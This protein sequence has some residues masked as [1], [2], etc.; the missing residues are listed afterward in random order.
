MKHLLRASHPARG[1][2]WAAID[3][4]VHHIEPE[5]RDSRFGARLAPFRSLGEAKAALI[6]AGALL[7]PQNG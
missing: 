5:V 7:E 1:T 2:L 6:A 3:P 4:D